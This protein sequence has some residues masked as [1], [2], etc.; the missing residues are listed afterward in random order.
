MQQP[1]SPSTFVLVHGMG[2][3][4]WCWDHTRSDLE[5]LG[6][7]VE[8][9]DLPLT[10]LADDA[11]CV[12][13]LLA[14]V[15]GPRTLVG[16][17]YG[18]LVISAAAVGQRVDRLVYVAAAMLPATDNLLDRAAP[19]PAPLGTHI[20]MHAD[21]TVTVP[22]DAALECFYGSCDPAEARWAAGQ[23]R[24]TAAGCLGTPTGHE[25]WH[26]TE[27]TYVVCLRDLAIAP[28]FQQQMAE[29]AARV[30]TIDTDHSP[31]LSARSELLVA[32]TS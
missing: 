17:S 14:E 13:A 31:F 12:A 19:Y 26:D 18:G 22:A 30:V 7:R 10:S 5:G 27:A 16:H 6:H 21:G 4:G 25:P 3:G 9:P 15:D 11:A 28:E 32:L 29:Q 1:S 23:L 8:A 20:E 24:P 2:H